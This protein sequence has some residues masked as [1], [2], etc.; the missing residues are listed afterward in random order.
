[1]AWLSPNK[2]KK[3][4]KKQLKTIRALT[5]HVNANY[6]FVN[7]GN[8]CLILLNVEGPAARFLFAG[9]VSPVEYEVLIRPQLKCKHNQLHT[10]KRLTTTNTHISRHTPPHQPNSFVR[11]YVSNFLSF[12]YFFSQPPYHFFSSAFLLLIL[13]IQVRLPT[14][15][16]T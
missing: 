1:M 6:H 2:T 10:T 3:K 15:S 14:Y 4:T 16:F 11:S 12:L 13:L 8:M 7:D 9:F 5:R